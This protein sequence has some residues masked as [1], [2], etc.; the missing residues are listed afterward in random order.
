MIVRKNYEHGGYHEPPDG[1]T[2]EDYIRQMYAE[3]RFNPKAGSPVGAAGLAQIM[4]STREYMIGRYNLPETVD[5][6]NP[7]DARTMQRKY[8]EDLYGRDWNTGTDENKKLKAL[9]AYNYGPTNV[10]RALEKAKKKGYDIYDDTSWTKDPKVLPK[11]TRDYLDRTYFATDEAFERE[12]S[13]ARPKYFE[14]FPDDVEQ[15]RTT[16]EAPEPIQ[17]ID[18]KLQ[19]ALEMI[20]QQPA[21]D[22]Q[23]K[24]AFKIMGFKGYKDGGVTVKKYEHGGSHPTREERIPP[25]QRQREEVPYD[26]IYNPSGGVL[27]SNFLEQVRQQ[28][29]D[30]TFPYA[31][32]PYGIARG[33][34]RVGDVLGIGSDFTPYLGDAKEA[35]RIQ[36]DLEEGNYLD[37]AIGAGL[38]VFPGAVASKAG[39]YIKKGAQRVMNFLRPKADEITDAA[40]A[41]FSQ[42]RNEPNINKLQ[43]SES[44][45]M[46]AGL[47]ESDRVVAERL[48]DYFTEEGQRR[49]KEQIVDQVKYYDELSNASDEYLGRLGFRPQDIHVLRQHMKKFR[50]TAGDIDPDSPAILMGLQKQ[51]QQ[52]RRLVNKSGEVV[53]RAEM[54]DK[55]LT[56]ITQL[57]KRLDEA[58]DAGDYQ[59]VSDLQDLIDQTSQAFATRQSLIQKELTNAHYQTSILDLPPNIK[60][61]REYLVDPEAARLASIHEMQHGMADVPTGLFPTGS[62]MNLPKTV[63]AD[64]ILDDLVLID[65]QNRAIKTAPTDPLWSDLDYFIRDKTGRLSEKS[66]FLSEMREDML[67]KGF[68]SS[69]HD[70]VDDA[71]IDRYLKDY[72]SRRDV[73]R[74]TTDYNTGTI[75]IL[76]IMD[77]NTGPY[78]AGVLKKALNK[79]LVAVPAV[80]AAGVAA[81]ASADDGSAYYNGGKLRLKKSKSYGMGVRKK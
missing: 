61:G 43:L 7:Q 21:V 56:A 22:P 37:A 77:P 20:P 2:L 9:A 45:K 39:P 69:R 31:F 58:M 55:S 40:T 38:F 29:A 73:S 34:A 13:S 18:P 5:V 28:V 54:D 14:L 41:G 76:E 46:R 15:S 71:L 27:G 51:N 53:K 47:E 48:D 33:E 3:S 79:M 8:M 64:R 57:R 42:I 59:R 24:Q 49:A 19:D 78:N 30:I 81:G 11:E 25:S 52:M 36:Q 50:N 32:G 80:G 67:K 35:A 70:V 63:E 65:K 74:P 60:L 10:I 23:L 75:R 62:Q 6:Y 16:V 26:P 4:P 68:I 66:P 17:K 72:Y 44:N 12:Y 1:F